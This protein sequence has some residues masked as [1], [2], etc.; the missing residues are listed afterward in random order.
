MALKSSNKKKTLHYVFSDKHKNYIR[1][2]KNNTYN[3]AEGAVRAGKTVDNVFAFAQ[4]IMNSSQRIHLATG[5]TVGNAK[6]NIGDCNGFGLE[7]IFRGQCRWSKYKDNE[8]LIINGISTGRQEKVII[9][10]GGGKADSY[11]RIRGNT[12]EKVISTE[13][14]LY[15]Q[16][17]IKEIISRTLISD[18]R[19]F[20]WDL[21]PDH[22][23]H[24]IYTEYI[25]KYSKMQKDGNFPSGINYEHF[26]IR[27]N[28]ILT[29]VR[30]NEIEAEYDPY[31]IWYKRDILG[32]RVIAEGL[33]Y[34][35]FADNPDKF[36]IKN[37]QNI[38]FINIGIDFGG[39][40]SKHAFVCTGITRGFRELIALDSTRVE[41]ATPEDLNTAFT[42]YIKKI[43]DRYG[44]ITSIKADNAEP[45]LIRGMNTALGKAGIPF[46]I[47]LA[48]K[49]NVNNRIRA[50]NS[51]IAQGRF[52]I[53]KEAKSLE[54]AMAMASWDSKK[55]EDTRLDDLTTDID[56]LDAFEYS[57]E[58]H[59]TR[60]LP[61]M[62][63]T[64]NRKRL[65]NI[66]K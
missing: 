9:F 38:Q 62:S 27:D 59:I 33:I 57:F 52:F 65:S 32:L 61:T 6:L 37:P 25:D 63:T 35:V 30:I 46:A 31:S 10:A 23:N 55:I 36:L 3:V 64:S 47:E 22:P 8:A 26:T 4:E 50:T 24:W 1:K 45:V 12:Y 28:A 29:D 16:D 56:S 14:N 53:T 39:D 17:S 48:R 54:T 20:F 11:K 15:N 34:R 41:P 43:V 44:F 58:N 21:N 7:Y 66:F 2:C 42:N 18:E 19:K 60:L 13:V 49:S 5:S 40:K 51:L